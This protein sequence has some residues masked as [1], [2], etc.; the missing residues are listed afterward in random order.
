MV[1]GVRV[2]KK[3]W[4]VV[5]HLKER[6]TSFADLGETGNERNRE[7]RFNELSMLILLSQEA[8]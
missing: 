3:D 2:M 1:Q 8:Y 5:E 7:M 4:M 6:E